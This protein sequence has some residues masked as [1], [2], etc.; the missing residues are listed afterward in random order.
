MNK[1]FLILGILLCVGCFSPGDDII[2]ETSASQFSTFNTDTDTDSNWNSNSNSNSNP[3][4]ESI[5][6]LIIETTGSPP[7]SS[8]SSTSNESTSITDSVFETSTSEFESGSETTLI[9]QQECGNFIVEN[10]EQ[11][12]EGEIGSK[13]CTNLCTVSACGDGIINLV[14]DEKCDDNNL[15]DEDN[16]SNDC[17]S[18]RTI[19]LTSDYI[20]PPNFGGVLKAD[21][22]CQNDAI[23]FG[24]PG[25]YVAWISEDN[26]NASTRLN[27]SNFKGWYKSPPDQINYARTITK[28]WGGLQNQLLNP[29][30][31]IPNGLEDVTV[32]AVWTDTNLNGNISNNGNCQNWTSLINGS[33]G[34]GFPQSVIAWSNSG[35]ISCSSG[36]GAKLYCFQI[37]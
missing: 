19:F 23:K 29:I 20:G 32:Q 27:S 34:T 18:P 28:G 7:N 37:D 25:K 15:E 1:K 16:C 30:N 22:Y 35:T 2:S 13:N 5:A 3:T 24:L 12:D 9:S 4:T 21:E 36:M 26:S 11:C 10:S 6:T 17:Q 31:I 33:S 8:E 14:A